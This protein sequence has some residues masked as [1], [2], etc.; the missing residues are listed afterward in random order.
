MTKK[1]LVT[2][3]SGFIGCNLVKKLLSK[4]YKVYALD[5]FSKV[6]IPESYKNHKSLNYIYS[7]IDIANSKKIIPILKKFNP[8]FIIHLAAESHVDRSIDTPEEFFKNNVIGT[9][10]FYNSILKVKNKNLKIIHVSTDEVYGSIDKGSFSEKSNYD[11][12]SPYSASKA[13]SDFVAKSYFHTFQLPVTVL[14]LC[15]NFGPYQFLEKFIPKII[16]NILNKK[17]IPIYGKGKNIREWI[18]V[19]DCCS[20]IVDSLDNLKIGTNYN[21]GSGV[22]VNNI[23]IV[24]LIFNSMKIKKIINHKKKLKDF[25]EFVEDRPGHDFRYALNSDVFRAIFKW[26]P[27]YSLQDGISQTIDWY[28]NNPKFVKYCRAKYTGE[29]QGL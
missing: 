2:G 10:I 7:K 18:Y 14:N 29:R 23:K 15:N 11:P 22:R 13:G 16:I 26:K 4:K 21:I 20:A 3:A 1:V 6:S 19:E 24:K 25:V 9:S 27:K 12:R 5:K 8:N 28:L 17:K